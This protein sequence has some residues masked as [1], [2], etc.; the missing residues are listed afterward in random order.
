MSKQLKDL[1]FKLEKDIQATLISLK[2]DRNDEVRVNE[3]K[4]ET[5]LRTNELKTDWIEVC[6]LKIK[7]TENWLWIE[8]CK[9]EYLG[10]KSEEACHYL[11][12]ETQIFD[13][14][15][16]KCVKVNRLT[17]EPPAP[18]PPAP[19][20]DLSCLILEDSLKILVLVRVMCGWNSGMFVRPNLDL[21]LW[22]SWCPSTI[23]VLTHNLPGLLSFLDPK[24]LKRKEERN[25]LCQ[26]WITIFV[27]VKLLSWKDMKLT[28]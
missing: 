26:L 16:V 12:K 5:W 3:S 7:W 8:V 1:H 27:I 14:T 13:K 10:E 17:P 19:A 18:V 20:T 2:S 21:I 28:L 11:V 25:Y 9:Y 15:E 24:N 6:K 22:N 4:A 23:I